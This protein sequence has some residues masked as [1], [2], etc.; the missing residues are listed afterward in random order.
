MSFSD[1]Y[2]PDASSNTL[3]ATLGVG[4]LLTPPV[5]PTKV[6]KVLPAQDE[7]DFIVQQIWNTI[8][9]L[10]QVQEAPETSRAPGH[11]AQEAIEAYEGDDGDAPGEIDPDY[12]H[13]LPNYRG[14][15]LTAGALISLSALAAQM[16]K[17]QAIV[18][19]GTVSPNALQ[20]VPTQAQAVQARKKTTKPRK[21][22][23]ESLAP[24]PGQEK[25]ETPRTSYTRCKDHTKQDDKDVEVLECDKCQMTKQVNSILQENRRK[26]EAIKQQKVIDEAKKASKEAPIR[27]IKSDPCLERTA[28]RNKAV[29]GLLLK[30]HKSKDK[31]LA[32]IEKLV[33]PDHLEKLKKELLRREARGQFPY[34]PI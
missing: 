21:P 31:T 34:G 27:R 33:S 12:A 32:E 9:N 8:I 17:Q 11:S 5:S 15:V 7:D 23:C 19:Q 10:E 24:V 30:L 18:T 6:Q 20:V 4:L 25:T 1:Q 13:L 3:D 14:P 2:L 29:H 26:A 28:A 22:S 16:E